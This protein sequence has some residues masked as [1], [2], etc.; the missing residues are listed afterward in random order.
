ANLVNPT[1]VADA[2]G[3]YSLQLVVND[4]LVN[5]ASDGILIVTA[6]RP[7]IANAGPDQ[8]DIPINGTVALDGS[9]STDP[10]GAPLTYSWAFVQRPAGSTAT[11]VNATT[12]TP[13]FTTDR[14]GRFR[15]S[16]TVSD[17]QA[18]ASDNVD[19]TT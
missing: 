11:L 6:N 12:A 2:P 8:S 9:A 7:P 19:I 3:A 10:D 17:G 14:Q 15:L 18:A 1:F 13:S 5:S 16:L 4:G